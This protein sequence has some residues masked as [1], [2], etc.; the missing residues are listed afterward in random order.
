M[1]NAFKLRLIL[2]NLCNVLKG[3]ECRYCRTII[4]VNKL[5]RCIEMTRIN[6]RGYDPVFNLKLFKL[7]V[8][9]IFG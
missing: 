5:T 9:I 3:P 4:I 1:S 7:F 8:N 2:F 6:R